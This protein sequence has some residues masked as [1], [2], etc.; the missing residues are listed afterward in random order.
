MALQSDGTWVEAPPRCGFNLNSFVPDRIFIDSFGVKWFTV[1]A[2]TNLRLLRGVL[3]FDS[4]AS[5]EDGSD[6]ACRFFDREGKIGRASC[7]A[8]EHRAGDNGERRG[9]Y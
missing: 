6:D 3:V 1:V 7:R 8:R 2:A 9:I 4:G 5:L